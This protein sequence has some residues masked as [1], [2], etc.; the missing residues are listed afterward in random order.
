[1]VFGVAVVAVLLIKTDW[2]SIRVSRY[3]NRAL[4]GAAD[5]HVEIGDFGGSVISDI[6]A[7]D[8][9]ITR[10][11]NPAE[12]LVV[13]N[14]VS[15]VY[16]IRDIWKRRWVIE[17]AVIDSPRVYLPR[18]SVATYLSSLF[19]GDSA[20]ETSPRPFALFDFDLH[21][22]VINGGQALRREDSTAIVDSLDLRISSSSHGDVI[23]AQLHFAE[24]VVEHFGRV[25][26]SG[27]LH[28][29]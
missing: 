1:L 5:L 15:A 21:S 2:L 20:K 13:I 28:S 29:E 3:V 8:V 26:A 17:M 12:T 24:G 14:S 11:Q 10:A 16:D 27:M 6:A 7:E 18:D 19:R 25:S 22:L 4:E 23:T 9:V